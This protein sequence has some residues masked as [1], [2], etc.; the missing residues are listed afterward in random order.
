MMR[1]L[2][3]TWRSRLPSLLLLAALLAIPAAGRA[4]THHDLAAIGSEA[5]A[6]RVPVMLVFWSDSCGYCELLDEEVLTPLRASSSYPKRLRLVRIE[7]GRQLYT[8]FDGNPIS[9]SDLALRYRVQ[10]TPTVLLVDSA[11]QPL[12]NPLVGLASIDFYWAY[13][14]QALEEAEATLREGG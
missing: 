1:S 12:A 7:F 14:D 2:I 3:P 6:A 8:D 11:G 4:V 9:G 13:F 5:A 10:V